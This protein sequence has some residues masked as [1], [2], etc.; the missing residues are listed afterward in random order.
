M[1]PGL[2]KKPHVVLYSLLKPAALP[3]RPAS[4]VIEPSQWLSRFA[5][6][7]MD[8]PFCTTFRM[9]WE[10]R[11]ILRMQTNAVFA[12]PLRGL[13]H[14]FKTTP[15]CALLWNRESIDAQHWR[16]IRVALQEKKKKDLDV[17]SRYRNDHSRSTISRPSL[18]RMATEEAK[19]DRWLGYILQLLEG[20]TVKFRCL[21]FH[22]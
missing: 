20:N 2:S 11:D 15:S 5:M 21:C 4:L 10:S 9:L 6:P 17:R 1:R 8:K 12:W 18:A 22:L 3:T 19:F 7:E 14:A 16:E 13:Q